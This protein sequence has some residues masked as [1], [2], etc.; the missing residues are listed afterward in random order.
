MSKKRRVA[1]VERPVLRLELEPPPEYQEP[2][3]RE[4][5]EPKRGVLIEPI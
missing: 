1:E 5:E 3:K 2:K 4:E